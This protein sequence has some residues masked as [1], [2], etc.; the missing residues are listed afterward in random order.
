MKESEPKSDISSLIAKN[1][2]ANFHELS[3]KEKL[4]GEESEL[5]NPL[6]KWST[7]GGI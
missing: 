3:E 5:S 7:G 2:T 1:M 6:T 4:A